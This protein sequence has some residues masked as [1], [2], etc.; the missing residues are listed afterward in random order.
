[1][2]K[3][4]YFLSLALIMAITT[5]CGGGNEPQNP[6]GPDTPA[7]GEKDSVYA[8]NQLFD[9]FEAIR[10]L[11]GKDVSAASTAF[12]GMGL[13]QATDVMYYKYYD[14]YGIQ[15]NFEANASGVIYTVT[16]TMT[17]Y[18]PDGATN[19]KPIMV[20]SLIKDAVQKMGDNIVIGNGI[21]CRFW[22]MYNQIGSKWAGSVEEY[23]DYVNS[24]S[25]NATNTIWLDE[26]IPTYSLDEP[27]KWTGVSMNVHTFAIEGSDVNEFSVAYQIND[28]KLM[29]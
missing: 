11:V 27:G 29:D 4:F 22:A 28:L 21:N 13:E 26:T 25:L 2:K 24:G 12:L 19:Y 1:M 10:G 18:K 16:C 6:Q 3:L 7:P 15:A 20:T 14:N 23:M 8:K 5:N 17:P 9:C